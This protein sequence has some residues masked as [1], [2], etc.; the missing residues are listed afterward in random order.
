MPV[1]KEIG[2]DRKIISSDDGEEGDGEFLK[3]PPLS[4]SSFY[5]E[6]R[7]KQGMLHI[8]SPSQCGYPRETPDRH[9]GISQKTA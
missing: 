9:A 2:K 1:R 7:M 8:V 3:L 5:Y 6:R 4:L